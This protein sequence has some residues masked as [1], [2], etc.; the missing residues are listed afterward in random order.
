MGG[1]IVDSLKNIWSEQ[2]AQLLALTINIAI[3]TATEVYTLK[4]TSLNF[5]RLNDLCKR[6]FTSLVDDK[7]LTR[8][9][10]ANIITLYVECGLQNRTLTCQHHKLIVLVIECRTYAPWVAHREHLARTRNSAHYVATI[11]MSHCGFEHIAHL[12]MVFNIFCNFYILHLHS[13]GSHKVSFN[14]SVQAMPHE[15]EHDVRVAIY[16]WTLSLTSKQR[17]HLFDVC[18]V[19]VATQAKVLCP[20]VIATKERMHIRDSALSCC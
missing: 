19:E 10:L 14:L 9:K 7:S 6:T 3:R 13:L 8:L 18:H 16:S 4:R 15:F 2:L 11:E 12:H 20:P 5:F 1:I 17:E